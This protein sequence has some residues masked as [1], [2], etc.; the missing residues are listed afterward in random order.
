MR[1]PWA[2]PHDMKPSGPLEPGLA[3]R[4]ISTMASAKRSAPL[5]LV[6]IIGAGSA[7]RCA[8]LI[9]LDDLHEVECAADCESGA[10]G[11]SGATSSSTRATTSS[12]SGSTTTRA[13]TGAAGAST[14]I[15]T[16]SSSAGATTGGAGSG[17]AAGGTGPG[18]AGREAGNAGSTG[19][20]GSSSGSP[21]GGQSFREELIDS[22]DDNR[23]PHLISQSH[24]RVGY[25]FT[26]NDGT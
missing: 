8:P 17:G 1:H 5:L 9:G 22:C 20:A 3:A 26:I 24:G 18:D 16:T 4:R 10:G 11:G 2:H 25:W 7:L 19:A 23:V 14:S 13:S 6:A 21:D 12:T 15:G